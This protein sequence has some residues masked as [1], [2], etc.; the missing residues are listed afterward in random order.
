MR[1][2]NKKKTMDQ[3]SKSKKENIA[4]FV[5]KG[6]FLEYPFLID[7]CIKRFIDDF[8]NFFIEKNGKYVLTKKFSNK[9]LE[10]LFS[11]YLSEERSRIVSEIS[12]SDSLSKNAIVIV[13]ASGNERHVAYGLKESDIEIG[14]DKIEKVLN[15]IFDRWF[16]KKKD[17]IFL[18]CKHNW[19]TSSDWEKIC[20]KK[21]FGKKNF[22]VLSS[23][24]LKTISEKVDS[25][26]IRSLSK[27][28]QDLIVNEAVDWILL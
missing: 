15:K 13:S 12:K 8:Q 24:D 28:D 22:V 18:F 16:K 4:S 20:K 26:K 3:S 21:V 5:P 25:E 14:I 6:Y 9:N 17:G 10:I 23:S 27:E 1:N 2:L 11:S 19:L 7:V